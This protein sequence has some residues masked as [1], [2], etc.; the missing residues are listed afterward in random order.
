M[1]YALASAA[2]HS[3]VPDHPTR[4]T[5]EIRAWGVLHVS[6]R[7]RD[8]LSLIE[9]QSAAGMHPWLLTAAHDCSTAS[10]LTTWQHVREWRR[11]ILETEPTWNGDIV[12]AHSFA[13]GMAAVRNCAAV[14][15]DLSAFV[16]GISGEAHLELNSWLARSFRVAEQF[17]I[18]RAAAVVV[19]TP[20]MLQR[21]L[22]RGADPAG[23]FLV[24]PLLPPAETARAYDRIYRHAYELRKRPNGR[25]YPPGLQPVAACL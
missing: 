13:S 7:A 5:R 14:V 6:E 25:G 12:H 9:I 17:V 15:Y 18:A 4:A 11:I 21:V 10:L 19:H 23:A 20:E 22:R 8:A 3:P 1:P 2:L 24:D 16:E